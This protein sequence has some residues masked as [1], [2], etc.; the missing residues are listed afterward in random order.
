M[1]LKYLSLPAPTDSTLPA[2]PVVLTRIERDKWRLCW[3]RREYMKLYGITSNDWAISIYPRH[4]R[5]CL[6]RALF[7]PEVYSSKTSSAEGGSTSAG[8]AWD[9]GSS[10]LLRY[11]RILRAALSGSAARFLQRLGRQFVLQREVNNHFQEIDA[12]DSGAGARP[13]QP[14]LKHRSMFFWD[15]WQGPYRNE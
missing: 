12:P 3:V 6:G 11:L 13:R 14:R 4:G 5:R 9:V 15:C 7:E 1:L 2:D 10:Q 8:S